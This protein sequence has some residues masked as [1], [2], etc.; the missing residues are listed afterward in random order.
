ML[1][2]VR[3]C[4]WTSLYNV[5][6]LDLTPFNP[7]AIACATVDGRLYGIPYSNMS[8]ILVYRADLFEYYGFE[9]PRTLDEL[10]H[11]AVGLRQALLADGQNNT[12]GLISRGKPGAGAKRAGPGPTIAPCFG[13][14]GMTAK[15]GRPSTARPWW[16]ALAYYADL[17]QQAAPPDLG[18]ARLVQRLGALLQ[19]RSGDVYRSGLRDRQMVRPEIAYRR[20]DTGDARAGRSGRRPPR[21][22]VRTGLEHPIQIAHTWRPP[23]SLSAD[24]RG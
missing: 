4:R 8:N 6:A 23:G 24:F 15:A 13:A 21:R 9:P 7:A 16:P 12:Y 17:L 11:V 20:T 1:G 2:V 5:M 22:P 14:T 3:L 10:R 18:R 19:G